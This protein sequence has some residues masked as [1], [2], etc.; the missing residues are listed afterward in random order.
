MLKYFAH[1]SD[2]QSMITNVVNVDKAV[3]TYQVRL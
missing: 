2:L 3:L 1:V